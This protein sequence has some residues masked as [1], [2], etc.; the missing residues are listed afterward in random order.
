VPGSAALLVV[1]ARSRAALIRYA[2]RL[3]DFL[4][5]EPAAAPPVDLADLAFT[6]QVGRDPMPER[7]AVLA[8][9]REQA[10]ER[11]CA[12]AA[13]E[14]A[15]PAGVYAGRASKPG[16][17]V[18]RRGEAWRRY[19]EALVA[20]H[21]LD[22][23]AGLWVAGEE[24]E[25]RLLHGERHNRRRV[26]V[27]TYPF[28]PTR[29]WAAA[30]HRPGRAAVSVEP[31]S[32]PHPL[33]DADTSSFDRQEFVTRLT[34]REPY[35]RDH[36]VAGAPILPGAV[37][38]EMARAAG[39]L[40][41]TDGTAVNRIEDLVWAAP[42]TVRD[43]ALALSVRLT[44]D[45]DNPQRIGFE[46]VTQ[47]R[48]G[49]RRHAS[50]VVV[51]RPVA[52][53]EPHRIEPERIRRECSNLLA[54][55]DCYRRFQAIGV[56]YGPSFQVIEQLAVGET[57]ALARLRAPRR[58]ADRTAAACR[59]EPALIDGALQTAG[60]IVSAA[61]ASAPEYLPYSVGAIELLAA[62]LTP[63]R[64]AYARRSDDGEADDV[65]TFEITLADDDGRVLAS[66]ERLTLRTAGLSESAGA[67]SARE[68]ADA[69]AQELLSFEPYWQKADHCEEPETEVPDR[70]AATLVVLDGD[71]SGA[72]LGASLAEAGEDVITVDLTAGPD[73]TRIVGDLA[74]RVTDP[75][76]VHLPPLGDGVE[77]ALG[78][79]LRT[80]LGFCRAWIAGRG[81][82]ARYLYLYPEGS[83]G[84]PAH[85]AIGG[86]ACAVRAEHPDLRISAV[87]YD[88][89]AS[90]ASQVLTQLAGDS[91]A[92]VRFDG[93]R[94]FVR[95]WR[96][97]ALPQV[98]RSLLTTPGAHVITGGTGAIGMRLAES[99]T[100][101]GSAPGI[102]LVAR[103]APSPEARERIDRM[104]AGGARVLSMRADVTRREEV[105]AV[106]GAAREQFERIA[107]IF[108]AA[109]LLRD[110]FVLR[111]TDAAA[112]EV[113]GPKVLG[114]CW[115]DEET[116]DD[117]LDYFALFSSTAAVLGSVGQSDYAFA[118]SF[119]DHFAARRE[120]QRRE[121]SRQGRTLAINWP[122]WRDGGIV[123]DAARQREMQ[124]ELGLSPLAAD[125]A[126]DGLERALGTDAPQLL[127]A[128]GDAAAIAR[129]LAGDRTAP[130]AGRVSPPEH[131]EPPA[132]SGASPGDLRP[133]VERFLTDLL[134]EQLNLPAEDIDPQER[135]ERYGVDSLLTISLTRA[136]EAHF[137]TLSKTLFFE[138]FTLAELGDYFLAEHAGRVSEVVGAGATTSPAA[139]PP[140][141]APAPAPTPERPVAATATRASATGATPASPRDDEIAIIGVSG[142]YPQSDDLREFWSNLCQGRDCIE[143]I[144]PSR[145]DHA[146]YYDPDRRAAGKA[147]AKWGGLLRDIDHCDPMFFRM[148]KLEAE[149][150]DP[151]ERIF[152]ETVWHL[153]ED[154]GLT[155]EQLTAFRTGV[156]VGLMY[157]HYQLYGVEQ[158]LRGDG[159]PTSSSYASVANRVS[160]FFDF[161]GPSVALDTMCSSSLVAIHMACQ[162]IRSG[163]CEL[164]VAGGVN[165]SSHPLKYL[166]LSR[167]GFLSTDGRCRS[168][169]DGGDGY[170]PAEGSGAVLL[171]RRAAAEAD[172][173]RI[174]AI[175]A[176][177]GVNHGGAGQGFSVPNAR[178]QG[179]VIAAALDRAG[180]T[181]RA[182]DYIEAH[183]TGTGLGDPIEITGLLR[184]FAGHDLSGH[185]IPIGSVK[186]NIGHAESAAGIAAVTKVLLQFRHGRL[187]P[188]LHADVLNANI[189]FADT[190]LRVQ[191][192]LADWPARIDVDGRRCPRRAAVSA[193]GAGGTNA[194]VLLEEY[195]PAGSTLE[196]YIPAG[197]TRE[198]TAT[199]PFVF[200][201]SARDAD[202]LRDYARRMAEFIAGDG[203][204][205]DLAAIMHTLQSGR[206]AMTHRL[207]IVC[208]DRRELLARLGDFLDGSSAPAIWTGA[209]QRGSRPDPPE[210]ASA[211][212]LAA[213]WAAGATVEWIRR[214]DGRPPDRVELPGY[215]FARERCWYGDDQP[216]AT[217]PAGAR[218]LTKGWEMSPLSPARRLP[219]SVAILASEATRAL[220]DRLA[221]K[222]SRARVLLT[223]EL[224]VAPERGRFDA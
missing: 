193:F 158:A 2:E 192:E 149:H 135:F 71:G 5:Q 40:S 25:W 224:E 137:G 22:A 14:S 26:R 126:L 123:M 130:A 84:E 48:S 23:L 104:I 30:N 27:P 98:D 175:V 34:G 140:T 66:I 116:K 18:R 85:A 202:C 4:N 182:L 181:P 187:V 138:Y 11:L 134:A 210:Q 215:P 8:S 69:A 67:G 147:Y 86:F 111:K 78:G 211:E 39:E 139:V 133:A 82:R 180:W 3:A 218:L 24:I 222:L 184:S 29:H 209:V 108:H 6:L 81:G 173:D 223:G 169:G 77:S 90:S 207:A 191:R 117:P 38:L 80:V 122:W 170:V 188:S 171:K 96:P 120:R 144:P 53:C 68:P 97:I 196:E 31:R 113:L 100:A 94:R 160:Y 43:G 47:H 107:G 168:F 58:P 159:V 28:E 146:L 91:P 186:S 212:A 41:R 178:S 132:R 205:L 195:I 155:R 176:G 217:T 136:L 12:F 33:L 203:G 201:L 162:A 115:L 129:A 87:A 157:G 59:L 216:D 105:A 73:F 7:L 52:A 199:P 46:I 119:M 121:R 42:V 106:L 9:S 10:R 219:T 50:G 206:E 145:W 74:G 220:A 183:G 214:L 161:N 189:D 99:L 64:Y 208:S 198:S 76:F 165:V 114:T 118:N 16:Q 164:A 83:A 150:I 142:R 172:G 19:I 102:V 166:Q 35:L 37:M 36:V 141:P 15:S 127:L 79:G 221:H 75:T 20:E 44:E 95:A 45:L 179:T 185:E 131:G 70:P 109:G 49:I 13:G 213:A 57:S 110:G 174:L 56:A 124:R 93:S 63:A 151:Q 17:P 62:D 112:F 190:P 61:D 60:S 204:E 177:S 125:L 55:E 54:G 51:A 143:E 163:D 1:S 72:A 154:A 167:G 156:Y 152:L 103:S 101:R 88:G 92:H 153:L 21:D 89:R 128:T 32:R 197:S 194:H 148:S 65:R 200:V